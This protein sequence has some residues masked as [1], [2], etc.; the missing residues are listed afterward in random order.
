MHRPIS[1]PN[2]N[3]S[4]ISGT[5]GIR[6]TGLTFLS[7][8]FTPS[9]QANVH[10]PYVLACTCPYL[11]QIGMDQKQLV[12]TKSKNCDKTWQVWQKMTSVKKHNK[13]D[14]TQQVW[15]NTTT[16][17]KCKCDICDIC[18]MVTFYKHIRSCQVWSGQIRPFPVRLCQVRTD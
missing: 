11:S 1:Q 13:N 8:Y 10:V 5:Y 9:M 7:T 16:L 15:Q 3:G 14:K 2:W 17:T 6:R 18:D 12:V 4:E